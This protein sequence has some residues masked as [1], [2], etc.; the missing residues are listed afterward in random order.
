M[1]WGV[2]PSRLLRTLRPLRLRTRR[3][4]FRARTC[5]LRPPTARP[6]GLRTLSRRMARDC[7][8]PTAQ[9]SR[10]LVGSASRSRL[11]PCSCWVSAGCR[12]VDNGLTA[13]GF[14]PAR[15]RSSRPPYDAFLLGNRTRWLCQ[16]VVV[17]K[18][19]RICARISARNNVPHVATNFSASANI[20]AVIGRFW[21]NRAGPSPWIIVFTAGCIA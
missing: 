11:G 20:I 8:R 10:C 7:R 1:F 19:A 21:I 13:S 2:L 16:R 12:L 18:S 4:R 15:G 17:I 3:V 9:P 6:C 5:A 14:C